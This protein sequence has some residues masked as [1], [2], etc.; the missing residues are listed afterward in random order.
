MKKDSTR[1]LLSTLIVLIIFALVDISAGVVLDKTMDKL[2]PYSGQLAKD[3]FRLHQLNTDVVIIGSSRGAH[4]YVSKQLSDS[5]DAYYGKHVSIYNAAI[6]GKFATSNCCAAEVILARYSPKLVIFDLSESQLRDKDVTDIE[7]SAPFYWSDS[8]LHRYISD[9]GIKEQL[10]MLSSL[11]RYNGK[12]LRI[13]ESFMM[14]V[15]VDDGYIPLYGATIDTLKQSKPAKTQT[16]ELN[17]Y[18]KSNFENVLKKYAAAEVPLVM[19]CSPQF[20]P[21]DNN[22]AMSKLCNQY[23][24][25]FIDLYNLSEFNLHPELFKDADHLNDDGAH[26]YTAMF[27]EHLKPYLPLLAKQAADETKEEIERIEDFQ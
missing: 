7:F 22:A 14:T 20:R 13:A 16:R 8:I 21:K 1:F 12:L 27:F 9:L 24:I 3:N 19:V 5:I 17:S 15:P 23:G 26:V 11:Y 25:P 4:H 6:D 2:P 18:K 10:L